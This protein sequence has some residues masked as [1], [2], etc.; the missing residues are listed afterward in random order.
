MRP[1]LYG[2]MRRF[3]KQAATPSAGVYVCLGV[4]SLECIENKNEKVPLV[5]WDQMALG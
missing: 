5:G 4:P 1:Y 3:V 2:G